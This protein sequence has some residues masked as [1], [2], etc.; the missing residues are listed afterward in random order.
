MRKFVLDNK[1]GSKDG[2]LSIEA[3][4]ATGTAG[5]LLIGL[6]SPLGP[7]DKAIV[8][9][10]KNAAAVLD[11]GAAPVF[12]TPVL[13][14][15]ARQGLRDLVR[16]G[17][18]GYLLIAGDPGEGGEFALWKWSGPGAGAALKRV[19]TIEK[20]AKKASAE[21]LALTPDNAAAW[22]LFDEGERKDD[23]GVECKDLT[24]PAKRFFHARRIDV[25]SF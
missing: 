6:R 18:G 21:A 2:G 4:T 8:L 17:R 23:A 20:P 24:A 3:V 11:T 14:D 5:E 15:L 25:S 16:D 7:G 12:G 13:L 19:A 22:I 1:K 9:V 10:L